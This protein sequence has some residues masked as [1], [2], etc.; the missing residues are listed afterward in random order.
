MAAG[1]FLTEKKIPHL[2][3]INTGRDEP[4]VWRN[5]LYYFT[6]LLFRR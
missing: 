3:R 6:Q 4:R 2:F 1:P 5:D